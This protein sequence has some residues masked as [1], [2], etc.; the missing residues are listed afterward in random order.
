MKRSFLLLCVALCFGNSIYGQS[1]FHVD[2]DGAFN[3]GLH[4]HSSYY[5]DSG[6]P[7]GYSYGL[8]LRYD[9]SER[10]SAGAGIALSREFNRNHR[11]A[12]IYAT[13]RYKALKQLPE[14][15]VFT[16]VGY[17]SSTLG[18]KLDSGFSGSLGIGYTKMFAKHFGLNFQLGYNLKTFN[19]EDMYGG[20]DHTDVRHSILF[21]VGV[22]F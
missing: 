3:L 20:D 14:T 19:N 1:R 18:S 6:H 15:Y 10:W 4:E 17:S 13:V 21:G 9:V 16:N 22:T 8:T 11:T 2:I 5:K 7:H 12:P